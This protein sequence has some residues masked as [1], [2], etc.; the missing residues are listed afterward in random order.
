MNL[1]DKQ[2]VTFF[3]WNGAEKP[4]GFSIRQFTNSQ[5]EY[6]SERIENR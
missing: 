5:I 4:A 6:G 3:Q 1:I 2:M